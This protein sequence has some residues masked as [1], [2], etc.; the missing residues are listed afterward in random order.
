MTNKRYVPGQWYGHCGRQLILKSKEGHRESWHIR[1]NQ[2]ASP[3]MA[4]GL[5]E[6][7]VVCDV[8]TEL[9]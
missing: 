2:A 8:I 3:G 5:L 4:N 9:R 6:Q 1:R 7:V